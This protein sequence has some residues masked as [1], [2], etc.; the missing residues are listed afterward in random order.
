[1]ME[2]EEVEIPPLLVEEATEV[3]EE[4]EEVPQLPSITWAPLFHD[5]TN[6]QSLE[7]NQEVPT[8]PADDMLMEL[9]AAMEMD[10]VASILDLDSENQYYGEAVNDEDTTTGDDD[11]DINSDN[12]RNQQDYDIETGIVHESEESVSTTPSENEESDEQR[13]DILARNGEETQ[14]RRTWSQGTVEWLRFGF[15]I[16][17]FPALVVVSVVIPVL[18]VIFC[19]ALLL[20]GLL[21]LLCVYYSGCSR[22]GGQTAVPFHVLVRQILEAVEDETNGLGENAATPKYSRE[23]IQNS[24]V[25]RKLIH[26]V[27]HDNKGGL[28]EN[29]TEPNDEATR[30]E[31]MHQDMFYV[32]PDPSSAAPVEDDGSNTDKEDISGKNDSKHVGLLGRRKQR[33]RQKRKRKDAEA[34]IMSRN[35]TYDLRL[36]QRQLTFRTDPTRNHSKLYKHIRTYVFSEPLKPQVIEQQQNRNTSSGLRENNSGDNDWFGNP[37]RTLNN[38]RDSERQAITS[39]FDSGDASSSSSEHYYFPMPL[40]L[41]DDSSSSSSTSSSHIG[42]P[43]S[44]ETSDESYLITADEDSNSRQSIENEQ[45]EYNDNSSINN[46]QPNVIDCVEA[47]KVIRDFRKTVPSQTETPQTEK[48]EQLPMEEKVLNNDCQE[49]ELEKRESD[50]TADS[51]TLVVDT[52]L[53]CATEDEAADPYKKSSVDCNRLSSNI[54]AEDSIVSCLESCTFDV[55]RE[56][57][58]GSAHRQDVEAK[59]ELI[60]YVNSTESK[61][62]EGIGQAHL[63]MTKVPGSEGEDIEAPDTLVDDAT[64]R[65]QTSP[66]PLDIRASSRGQGLPSSDFRNEQNLGGAD[67]S[68]GL[69]SPEANEGVAG[70][71]LMTDAVQSATRT[72]PLTHAS[73]L[74]G[75]STYCNICLLE[76]EI[77][78]IVVWSR[79]PNGC[80]HAWH[81]DC[82][83]D[84][85]KRKPTCPNCRQEYFAIE[86]S[87]LPH[88][89]V[90]EN[91]ESEAIHTILPESMHSTAPELGNARSPSAYWW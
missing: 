78:D 85:L 67:D 43:P 20:V 8:D 18:L 29:D 69:S 63:I 32:P 56:Q 86:D 77:G 33:Q 1:M 48:M 66:V 90:V 30:E 13:P 52:R 81:E 91:S 87:P 22:R 37:R 26:Y 2:P 83:L 21:V 73:D 84:W 19:F 15:R 14:E 54:E 60:A 55:D 3:T 46:V 10:D 41:S 74:R 88:D 7:E 79:R 89:N 49:P 38:G 58:L 28:I 36:A 61:K 44:R 34:A 4:E 45:R 70:T 76:Y 42:Q 62:V 71:N 9:Q 51:E 17:I 31:R 25:R 72:S 68:F 39:N 65:H 53:S 6:H 35:E 47:I 16:L 80:H 82:L 11:D 59:E 57:K 50:A 64:N 40:F 75:I 27:C 24:L 5:D 23:Q 12:H